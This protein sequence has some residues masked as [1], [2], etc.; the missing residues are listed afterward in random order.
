MTS[1]W[2]K[3]SS[4]TCMHA[5][6]TPAHEAWHGM[7]G[8]VICGMWPCDH[9]HW[10]GSCNASRNLPSLQAAHNYDYA[11]PEYYYDVLQ[12]LNGGT[13]VIQLETAAGAAIRNFHGAVGKLCLEKTARNGREVES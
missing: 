10:L 6:L 13:N 2:L 12:T 3:T 8:H 4:L 11:I 7:A 9:F 1:T 5:L